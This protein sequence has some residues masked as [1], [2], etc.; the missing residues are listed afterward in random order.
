[1]HNLTG[2][3]ESIVSGILKGNRPTFLSKPQMS[4]YLLRTA[5]LDF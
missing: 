1:M 5:E 4:M 2:D 3:G